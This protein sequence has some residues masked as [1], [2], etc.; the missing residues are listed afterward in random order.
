MVCRVSDHMP[1]MFARS[2]TKESEWYHKKLASQVWRISRGSYAIRR[3]YECP[4]DQ[5][6]IWFT[7]VQARLLS[8]SLLI[9]ASNLLWPFHWVFARCSILSWP[10]LKKT[11]HEGKLYEADLSVWAVERQGTFRTISKEVALWLKSCKTHKV[12][13]STA[14][15]RVKEMRPAFLLNSQTL[16]QKDKPLTGQGISPTSRA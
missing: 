2:W 13:R 16:L 14:Q 1:Y 9:V 6:H 7:A 5:L 8:I 15:T 11:Y 4:G 12:L 3:P 10:S